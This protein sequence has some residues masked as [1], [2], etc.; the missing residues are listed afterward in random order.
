[1]PD[2]S[3]PDGAAKRSTM[4]NAYVIEAGNEA[5]GIVI[6]EGHRFRFHSSSRRYWDLEGR[7]FRK[8]HDAQRAAL[9]LIALRPARASRALVRP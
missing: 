2:S 8:P 1:M 5:A 3:C 9:D 4:F 7:Y 6:R